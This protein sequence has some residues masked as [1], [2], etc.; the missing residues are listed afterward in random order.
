MPPLSMQKPTGAEDDQ[1]SNLCTYK[2]REMSTLYAL[3]IEA[4]RMVAGL[5]TEIHGDQ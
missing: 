4:D 3:D 5:A 2:N 1:R